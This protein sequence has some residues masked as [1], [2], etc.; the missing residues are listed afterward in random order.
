MKTPFNPEAAKAGAKVVTRDGR[1]VRIGIWDAK[2]VYPLIGAITDNN[3]SEYS[4]CWLEDG[5]I[6]SPPCV[7]DADLFMAPATIYVA[8][9]PYESANNAW[10]VS[11]GYADPEDVLFLVDEGW[12]LMKLVEIESDPE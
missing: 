4:Q 1:A 11:T 8:V 6:Y 2:S 3:G 12:K 5:T 7:H 10:H 9:T